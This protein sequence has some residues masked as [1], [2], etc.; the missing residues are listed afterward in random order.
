M[1]VRAVQDR[2]QRCCL[3]FAVASIA[4]ASGLVPVAQAEPF[5]AVSTYVN[6]GYG[7]LLRM[8]QGQPCSSNDVDRLGFNLQTGVSDLAIS[9]DGSRLYILDSM[10]RPRVAMVDRSSGRAFTFAGSQ[11]GARCVPANAA[12]GDGDLRTSA[13]VK[14]SQPM[15]MS[16]AGDGSL[17]IADQGDQNYGGRIR[18]VDGASGKL[19]TLAGCVEYIAGCVP[20]LNPYLFA[21]GRPSPIAALGSKLDDIVDVAAGQNG[22]AYVATYGEIYRVESG[23]ISFVINE[24]REFETQW[25]PVLRQGNCQNDPCPDTVARAGEASTDQISSIAISKNGELFFADGGLFKVRKISDTNGDGKF[26]YDDRLTT[27]AGNGEKCVPPT[28]P[29]NQPHTCPVSTA[30]ATKVEDVAQLAFDQAGNLYIGEDGINRILKVRADGSGS[31]GPQ[32]TVEHLYLAKAFDFSFDISIPAKMDIP[33]SYLHATNGFA[34]DNSGNAYISASLRGQVVTLGY[35]TPSSCNFGDP[36]RPTCK[37]PTQGDKQSE[38]T[39]TQTQKTTVT[40]KTCKE[41]SASASMAVMLRHNKKASLFRIRRYGLPAYITVSNPDTVVEVT[42]VGRSHSKRVVFA[43]KRRIKQPNKRLHIFLKAPKQV[44]RALP[45]EDLILKV[46]ARYRFK[47][48]DI[49][50]K[51]RVKGGKVL[52]MKKRGT[53]AK[54]RK[55]KRTKHKKSKRRSFC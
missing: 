27:V 22:V 33:E 41:K 13:N 12:C 46:S 15:G 52:A 17:Y 16:L 39:Q 5:D 47:S 4:A 38:S 2:G 44:A 48:K 26:D 53:G 42:A 40:T 54:H 14:F 28:N 31:V 49:T 6:G 29:P 30:A 25:G 23:A 20:P 50:L 32:S 1:R 10:L 51:G 24:P 36:Y 18:K 34:F 8:T 19:S 37:P 35:A 43:Y 3:I 7:C 9:S 45:N 55:R 11:N 21:R